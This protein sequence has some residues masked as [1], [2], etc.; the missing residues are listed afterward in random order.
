MVKVSLNI[1]LEEAKTKVINS[2]ESGMALEKFYQFVKYQGGKI[3]KLKVSEF[4]QEIKSEVEAQSK[5]AEEAKKAADAA[6]EEEAK[7]QAESS[8]QISKESSTQEV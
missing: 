7:K 6:A 2:L 1:S 5:H 3:E 4:K 8:E